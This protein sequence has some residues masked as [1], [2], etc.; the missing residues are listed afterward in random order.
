MY[1]GNYMKLA[2]SFKSIL[3]KIEKY[4]YKNLKPNLNFYEE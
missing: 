2:N 1:T 4:M 3:N